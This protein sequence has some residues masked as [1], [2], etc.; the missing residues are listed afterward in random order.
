MRRLRTSYSKIIRN[1]QDTIFHLSSLPPGQT[2]GFP[3]ATF[4][5][6]GHCMPLG[7]DG[8]VRVRK[9]HNFSNPEQ[10]TESD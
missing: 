10:V 2:F 9:Y 1:A 5:P 4:R 7:Q 6:F 8:G 3:T